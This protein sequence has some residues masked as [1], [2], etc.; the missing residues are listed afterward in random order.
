MADFDMDCPPL[1]ISSKY[2]I[3]SK[4]QRIINMFAC[5][6][7]QVQIILENILSIKYVAKVQAKQ[8]GLEEGKEE[9][10]EDATKDLDRSS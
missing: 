8:E 7:I 5:N 4:S 10:G 2:P 6:E 1:L 3:N 9:K